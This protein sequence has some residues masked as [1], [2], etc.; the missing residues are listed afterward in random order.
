M[1]S[2]SKLQIHSFVFF[3]FKIKVPGPISLLQLLVICKKLP[4]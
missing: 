4:L 1:F 2:K 3:F